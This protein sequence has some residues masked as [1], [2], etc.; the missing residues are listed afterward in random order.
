MLAEDELSLLIKSKYTVVFLETIDEDYALRQIKTIASNLRIIYH[1]WA[2]TTGLQRGNHDSPYYQTQDP[3]KMLRMVQYLV[4]AQQG[5]SDV[6]VL[7]DFHKH[8]ENELT[9]RL[10]KDLVNLMKTTRN[11]LILVGVD[12]SLPKDIESNA[13]HIIGG[14]PGEQDVF[15]L[16]TETARE[17]EETRRPIRMSRMS[18]TLAD[19]HRIIDALK[20][21]SIS[22]IRNIITQCIMTN[23]LLDINSLTLI[24]QHKKKVF[25]QAGLLEFILSESGENLANF[26]NLKRW[27]RE[28]QLSFTG[29][30]GSGLPPPKGVLLMGVQGCGKS[31]AIK[32]IG[33]E[34]KIPLYRLD[35]GALY[36]KYIGETEQNL[37]KA[38]EIAEKLAPLCLWID[39][40]EK[41]FAASGQDID[42]GVSQ[43]IMGTFLT[44]MQERK[45]LCF[46]AATANDVH[47]LPPEL[48]RK[49]RFDEIFFVDLPTH[50][51]R[52]SIFRIQLQK[53]NLDPDQFDC[54]RLAGETQDFSGAEIEQLVISALYHASNDQQPIV[55]EHV[56]EQIHATRTLAQLKQEDILAL[57]EWARDRTISA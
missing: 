7:K 15:K 17:L 55:T 18:L 28:R 56:L 36:S 22:Q 31:L 50:Q 11:T 10:F 14:Y 26:D 44:W 40:I 57:R 24:E 46:L 34:L 21:L 35:I 48:L 47:R 54:A 37:R 13:A 52:E 30:N 23:G 20:G 39:E 12:Y 16:I 27:L 51:T 8:L 45:A 43:R 29:D 9:L 32:I 4:S 19:M 25:D 6:F 38:L 2:L 3:I 5:E 1:Q 33:R 42:G 41:A 49:G 53:R